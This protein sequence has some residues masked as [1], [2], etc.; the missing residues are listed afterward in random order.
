MRLCIALLLCASTLASAEVAY[1]KEVN[2]LAENI[3]HE[4]RSQGDSG[5]VAVAHVT[6]NRVLSKR[7][8]D[9]VCGVV[10]Q[11]RT[12]PSWKTGK[13]TPIINKC[14]FSWYCDGKVDSIN[15]P[16][17]W[18]ASLNVAHDIYFH[19]IEADIHNDTVNGAMWYHATRVSPYWTSSMRQVAHIRKHVFYSY[20]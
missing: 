7:F 16:K 18:K 14:Q 6:I 17:A 2:C 15:E 19:R 9:T 3:Y 8:P 10:R 20:K 1:D 4:A 12:K 5:R 11:A 13:P